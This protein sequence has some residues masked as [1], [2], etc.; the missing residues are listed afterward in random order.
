[1]GDVTDKNDQIC[2]QHLKQSLTHFASNIPD[3]IRPQHR[4]GRNLVH[5]FKLFLS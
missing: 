2:D 5:T 3:Y 4:C 1:M